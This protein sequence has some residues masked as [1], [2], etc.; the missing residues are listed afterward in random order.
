MVGRNGWDPEDFRVW[1]GLV[2]D[3]LSYAIAT[4]LF[5]FGALAV[6]DT[7]ILGA[8]YGAGLVLLGLPVTV[9]VDKALR[10]TDDDQT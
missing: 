3:A 6:H 10:R 9:R 1:Q 7:T 8:M 4:F 2:R 5:L